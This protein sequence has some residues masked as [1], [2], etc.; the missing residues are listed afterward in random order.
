MSSEIDYILI[1]RNV[2]LRENK[3]CPYNQNIQSMLSFWDE[4]DRRNLLNKSTLIH[5]YTR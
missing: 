1:L 4:F 2:Q 5:D 3:K